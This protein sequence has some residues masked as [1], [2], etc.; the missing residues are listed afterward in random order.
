MDVEVYCAIRDA[1]G[2]HTKVDYN[3]KSV[4]IKDLPVGI[5]HLFL[6]KQL[7]AESQ[8]PNEITFT[9]LDI[10]MKKRMPVTGLASLLS[11]LNIRAVR[12]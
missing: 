1:I 7:V 5:Y 9:L 2:E 10:A 11:Q 12:N 6:D 3:E 8:N 4:L